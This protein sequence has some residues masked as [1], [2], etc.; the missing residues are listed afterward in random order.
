MGNLGR[1]GLGEDPEY[2][3]KTEKD[4][5]RLGE[6][7]GAIEDRHELFR[8]WT[9]KTSFLYLMVRLKL[10]YSACAMFYL[11]NRDQLYAK[12]YYYFS[13]KICN[14]NY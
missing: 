12:R 8:S 7:V 10:C 5:R 6:E 1:E 11:A 4:L 14:Q 3:G 2:N 13:I 9:I